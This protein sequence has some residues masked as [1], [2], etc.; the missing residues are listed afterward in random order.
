MPLLVLVAWAVIKCLMGV[1]CC[2]WGSGLHAFTLDG[3]TLDGG[4]ASHCNVGVVSVMHAIWSGVCVFE[5]RL[6]V[7]E[8]VG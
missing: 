5:P 2:G 6:W 3:F 1:V 7:A 8:S 4:Q